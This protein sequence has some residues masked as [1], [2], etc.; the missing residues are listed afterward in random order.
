M[1]VIGSYVARMKIPELRNYYKI[2]LSNTTIFITKIMCVFTI[3]RYMFP[4]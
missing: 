1:K 3:A 2:T 4:T